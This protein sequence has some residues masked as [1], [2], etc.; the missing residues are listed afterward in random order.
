MTLIKNTGRITTSNMNRIA[1]IQT[2]D[3]K[4][5]TAQDLAVLWGYSDEL[6]LFELI[7][8]YLKT[9]QIF[10]LTRGLYSSLNYSVEDLRGNANL[11]Y[12][13]ANRLVPNSYISLWTALKREGVI[14]QYYNEIYS[15]A[16][17]GV[18]R[19]VKG[20]NFVYKKIKDSVLMN[21]LGIVKV[22]QS[23]VAGVERAIGDT[24]YL[25]PSVKLEHT[26]LAKKKLLDKVVRMYD[27]KVVRAKVGQLWEE[28]NA[29]HSE[30]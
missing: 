15:V 26:S 1:Q 29:K 23:R 27:K 4:V 12:E 7:K 13:I 14:F 18:V 28:S 20:I 10:T 24:I 2:L 9:K 16:E 21:D 30:T 11:L 5:F 8:Y 19:Q 22:G 17:R 6:K 3:K 25:F